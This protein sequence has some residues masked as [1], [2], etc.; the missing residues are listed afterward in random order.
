MSLHK[1]LRNAGQPRLHTAL[2]MPSPCV[3][4]VTRV[5]GLEF[6]GAKGMRDVL[7][8]VAEAVGIVIRRIDA[9][10]RAHLRMWG[11]LDPIGH[12]VLFAILHGKLHTEGGLNGGQLI[13]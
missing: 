10:L 6:L 12:R 3:C 13:D 2:S 5:P 9:P 11:I 8:G 4:A 7:Y 1:D